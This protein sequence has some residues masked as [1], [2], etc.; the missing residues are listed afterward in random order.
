MAQH[1]SHL[2]TALYDAATIR[3]AEQAWAKHHQAPLFQLVEQ[4]GLAAFELLQQRIPATSRIV[5]IAG[6]GNNGADALICYFWLKQREFD[7]SLLVHSGKRATAE[8]QQAWQLLQAHDYAVADTE[9]DFADV[10]VIVDGLLGTGVRGELRED[11]AALVTCINRSKAIVFSLDLPSGINADTG[12]GNAI[13][14]DFTLCM[15]AMKQGLLTSKARNCTGLLYFA[16]IG[17]SEFLPEPEVK[18][19]GYEY[20]AGNLAARARDSHKGDSGRVTVIGGDYGMAGAVRLASEACLRSGAG[21]VTVVSRPEHQLTINSNRPELMFRGCELVDMEV[22]SRLGWAKVLVLGPGLGKQDWGYNLFKAV[23]LSDKPMVLDADALNLLS[24]EP[25]RET[26]W[27]LTPHPGEAAR[28]LAV[29]V[30]QVEQDRFAAVRELQQ[31]YGGVVLLKGAGTL[32]CDG[33]C[34]YVAPVG[35]P[36]LASGGCGDVLSGIIGALIA[37]GLDLSRATIAAVVIHGEAADKAAEDGERGMLASDLF[38]WIR[39][40]VNTV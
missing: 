36:G 1:L 2:P 28:L 22:Y 4:A 24:Q 40:L 19:V 21:L 12:T 3:D 9:A 18:R 32:I 27:V 31:R 39:R 37:Q 33:D 15:G 11:V 8:W 13:V 6:Q 30:E 38:P 10:D 16:D 14:A 34:V 7:V 26:R 17:L 25:R 20:L 29:D 23:G 5:V 35:N